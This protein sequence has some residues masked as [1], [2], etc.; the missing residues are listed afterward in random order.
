MIDLNQ[1]DISLFA[2]YFESRLTFVTESMRVHHTLGLFYFGF[3]SV[4]EIAVDEYKW[5]SYQ[6][7][8]FRRSEKESLMDMLVSPVCFYVRESFLY[9][10]M[11][12]YM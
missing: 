1:E 6:D 4:T 7:C 8:A 12:R 5:L 10:L 9:C 2:V 3:I 11:K